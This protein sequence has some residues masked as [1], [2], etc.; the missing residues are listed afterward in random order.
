MPTPEPENEKR[1]ETLADVEG[2][3]SFFAE[4]LYFLRKNKKWWLVPMLIS[5]LLFG[6][7]LLLSGTAAAPFIYTLF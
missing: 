1:S 6:I 3:P 5:L 2:E 4:L 7:L